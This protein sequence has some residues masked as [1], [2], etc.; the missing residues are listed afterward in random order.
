MRKLEPKYKGGPTGLM[1]I[2]HTYMHHTPMSQRP[3]LGAR[4]NTVGVDCVLEAT[5]VTQGVEV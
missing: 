5:S 3:C 2:T 4:F 1:Q